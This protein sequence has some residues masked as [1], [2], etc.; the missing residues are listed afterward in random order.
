MIS[1]ALNVYIRG[2]QEERDNLLRDLTGRKECK[3]KLLAELEKYK[4]CDP[5][6][7]ELM[8]QQTLTAKDAANRWTGNAILL[9]RF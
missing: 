3:E 8:K 7:M 2:S 4:A 6:V 5:E 1:Y 9:S